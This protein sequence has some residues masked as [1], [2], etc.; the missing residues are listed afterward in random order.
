MH[1]GMRDSNNHLPLIS[2]SSTPP[3]SQ[4]SNPYEPNASYDELAYT[5]TQRHP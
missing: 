4:Y 2:R 3:A 5:N 1:A